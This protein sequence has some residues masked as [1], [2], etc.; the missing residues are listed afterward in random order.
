MNNLLTEKK[1]LAVSVS[2][3]AAVEVGIAYPSEP[4]EK[5]V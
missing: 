2:T 4:S 3:Q 5:R 1:T